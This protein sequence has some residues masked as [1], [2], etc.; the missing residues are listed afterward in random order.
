M[1]EKAYERP[2]IPIYSVKDSREFKG[3]EAAEIAA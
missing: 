1:I 3:N 2:E